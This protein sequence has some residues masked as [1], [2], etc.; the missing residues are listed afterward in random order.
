MVETATV[1][2]VTVIAGQ[3]TTDGTINRA[4][5]AAS[6]S[7]SSYTKS[8]AGTTSTV[9]FNLEQNTDQLTRQDPPNNGTQSD[10]GPLGVNLTGIVGFDIR[11]GVDGL[12]QAALRTG[13]TGPFSLYTV[14]LSTGA[15]TLHR[16]TRGNAGLSQIG[17]ATGPANL[18]D[19][20][21]RF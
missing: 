4:S 5:G 1:N 2:G 20:A 19:L 18:V 16:N 6:V 10:I 14:S 13:T 12:A 11:G 7:S 21:I 17:A 9:L 3:T 8:F 15:A